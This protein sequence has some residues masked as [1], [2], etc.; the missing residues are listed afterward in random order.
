M[1]NLYTPP[2]RGV[3]DGQLP[4]EWVVALISDILLKREG[5]N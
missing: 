5:R 4:R 3:G 1:A 2:D